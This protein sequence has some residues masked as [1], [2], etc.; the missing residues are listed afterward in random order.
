MKFRLH[1]T[2]GPGLV[3]LFDPTTK[4]LNTHNM[5]KHWKVATNNIQPFDTDSYPDVYV[6]TEGVTSFALGWVVGLQYNEDAPSDC[7]Y[8]MA[9][10]IGSLDYFKVDIENLITQYSYYPL[11]VYDPIHFY[12]NMM[13]VYE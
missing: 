12:G 13:S 1:R 4:R 9:D 3:G 7:F 11:L 8:T 6:D 5:R 10:T 2:F